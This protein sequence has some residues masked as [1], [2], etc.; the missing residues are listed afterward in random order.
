MANLLL[1]ACVSTRTRA[2]VQYGSGSKQ[3]QV[4]STKDAC[5]NINNAQELRVPEPLLAA[6]RSA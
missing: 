3:L 2:C 6:A 4:K 5:D 1:R